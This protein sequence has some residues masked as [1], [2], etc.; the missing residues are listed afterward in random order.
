MQLVIQRFP[1]QSTAVAVAPGA[2]REAFAAWPSNGS[3]TPVSSASR[4]PASHRSTCYAGSFRPQNW[5]IHPG[6]Y[7]EGL[8]R[9]GPRGQYLLVI[10]RPAHDQCCLRPY[11]SSFVVEGLLYRSDL[12]L[13]F[14]YRWD[15]KRYGSKRYLAICRSTCTIQADLFLTQSTFVSSSEEMIHCCL[16]WLSLRRSIASPKNSDR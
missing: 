5:T 2:T 7:A 1:R 8:D 15:F 13:C 6:I 11:C 3:G 4:I 10:A 9:Y 12:G 16:L 14:R